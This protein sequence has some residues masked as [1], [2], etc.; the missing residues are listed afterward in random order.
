MKKPV[1]FVYDGQ[2]GDMLQEVAVHPAKIIGKAYKNA[3]CL[4]F[5]WYNVTNMRTGVILMMG[6]IAGILVCAFVYVI[7]ET[8]MTS[9]EE[10]TYS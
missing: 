6:V 8:L 7:R 4:D 9:G 3:E 1:S 10:D 2:A 5:L